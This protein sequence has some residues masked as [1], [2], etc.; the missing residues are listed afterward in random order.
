MLQQIDNYFIT[1]VISNCNDGTIYAATNPDFP[2]TKFAIRVVPRQLITPNKLLALDK[3]VFILKTI[4][5]ENI[6]KLK[7]TKITDQNYCLI[8]EYCNAGNLSSFIE[9]CESEKIS[10]TYLKMIIGQIVKGLDAFHSNKIV[11]NNL[12]INNTWLDM[13][14]D[15]LKVKLTDL[16]FAQFASSTDQE[17]YY[18]ILDIGRILQKLICGKCHEGDYIPSNLDVSDD[19]L[20]FLKSCFQI[21]GKKM[22]SLKAAKEHPFI[23]LDSDYDSNEEN[24]ND[25]LV[26][27]FDKEKIEEEFEMLSSGDFDTSD[28]ENK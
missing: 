28:Y 7:D 20:D 13:Q 15:S 19:C 27:E 18:D 11:Y 16:R 1:N 5:H 21:N 10:E 2:N 6:I 8:F 12:S 24:D 26:I 17:F 23:A 3:E 9:N 25:W 4:T 22:T 14:G